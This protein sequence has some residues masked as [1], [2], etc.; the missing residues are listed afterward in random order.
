MARSTSNPNATELA[1]L[2]ASLQRTDLARR[3]QIVKLLANQALPQKWHRCVHCQERVSKLKMIMRHRVKHI[4]F[5]GIG[6]AGMSARRS[7]LE[8]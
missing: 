1:Q 5:V 6:G 8:S 7:A 4:H 3:A 2:L